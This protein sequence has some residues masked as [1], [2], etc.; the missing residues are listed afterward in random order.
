MSVSR[1]LVRHAPEPLAV[2]A[3]AR[4]PK[5]RGFPGSDENLI[6]AGELVEASL[7]LAIKK[8]PPADRLRIGR[9][10]DLY[11]GG[12]CRI[13]TAGRPLRHAAL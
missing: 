10:L 13:I 6:L 2:L 4:S 7:P 12:V 8:F 9:V 3:N 11:P 1:M 5:V